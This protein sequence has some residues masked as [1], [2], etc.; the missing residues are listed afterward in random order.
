[1]SGVNHPTILSTEDL[2][3]VPVVRASLLAI[4]SYQ[5][6]STFKDK[7]AGRGRKALDAIRVASDL[8]GTVGGLAMLFSTKYAALGAKAVGAAY[9]FDIGSHAFRT[10]QH[11]SNRI[12]AWDAQYQLWKDGQ[13]PGLSPEPHLQ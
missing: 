3:V 2:W 4:N 13:K 1:M 12:S 7:D 9:A 11:G 6:I 5:C 8:A 10:I